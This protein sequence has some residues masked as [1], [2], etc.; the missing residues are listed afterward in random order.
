MRGDELLEEGFAFETVAF[1]VERA[2]QKAKLGA[3]GIDAGRYG[4]L[5][6]PTFLGHG[7]LKA[8]HESGISLLG[9][10]HMTQRFRLHRA[11]R[12][13]E[14]L[15]VAG[16]VT[17]IEAVPRGRRVRCRFSYRDREGRE[18]C[19]TERSGLRP[20][21]ARKRGPAGGGGSAPVEE[22]GFQQVAEHRLTPEGVAAYSD[23][24]MNAIHN[25]PEVAARYG[26]RAPIAAGLMGIHYYIAALAD[27]G[28][29]E[30]LDLAIRFLRPM[31]WDDRLSLR[32]RGSRMRLVNPEGKPV[33][34]AEFSLR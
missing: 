23:D 2:F 1:S 15:T 14:P 32:R 28:I 10:V 12:L 24:S 16:Q 17:R 13:D 6:D 21:P 19:E 25:D 3:A 26:F 30:R 29:P 7:A 20:D 22:E 31:F 18:V 9:Q 11:V 33:S 34:E 27:T 4:D 5:A 8:M